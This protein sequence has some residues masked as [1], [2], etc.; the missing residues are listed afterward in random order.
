MTTTRTNKKTTCHTHLTSVV[1]RA[2]YWY[3]LS[4]GVGRL[5]VRFHHAYVIP[6][7]LL[8][9]AVLTLPVGYSGPP[10]NLNDLSVKEMN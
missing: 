3:W 9:V 6:S 5:V 4:I 10:S 2:L 8:D 7:F 1:S